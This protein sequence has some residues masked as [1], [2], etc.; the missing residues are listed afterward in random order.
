MTAPEIPLAARGMS[1][2]AVMREVK[3]LIRFYERRK[4]NWLNAA[5]FTLWKLHGGPPLCFC[6]NCQRWRRR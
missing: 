2:A 6:G 3:S 1:D 5:E 4:K